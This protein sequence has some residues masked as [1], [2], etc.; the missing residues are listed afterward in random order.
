MITQQAETILM[1][2]GINFHRVAHPDQEAQSEQLK[3]ED[4]ETRES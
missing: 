1:K 4:I 2:E 3:A